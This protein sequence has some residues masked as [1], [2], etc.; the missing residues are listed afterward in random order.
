M[1]RA[2]TTRFCEMPLSSASLLSLARASGL[3]RRPICTLLFSVG[4]GGRPAGI[5]PGRLGRRRSFL[6]GVCLVTIIQ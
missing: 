4:S 6:E 3:T 5:L 2:S 1:I